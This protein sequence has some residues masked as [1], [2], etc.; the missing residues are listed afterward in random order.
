MAQSSDNAVYSSQVIDFVRVA[1]HFIDALIQPAP[2]K[3]SEFIR[4]L[5]HLLP[6]L[7]L[8]AIELPDVEAR[9]D[10]ANEK[11]VTE[12]EYE[13]LNH[14][15][16][17]RFGYLNDYLEILEPDFSEAD[18]PVPAS[19]AEDMADIYQDLKDFLMLY[20]MGNEDIMN[21]AVWECRLNFERYWGQKVL[22]SLRHIHKVLNGPEPIQEETL[23]P[24]DSERSDPPDTDQ[25][26]IARRQKDFQDP[27]NPE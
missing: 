20:Q 16:T 6:G 9:L 22:N 1:G 11:F 4:K 3:R 15:L 13:A 21:D 24:M 2:L 12:D 14:R 7:Y 27:D 17:A 18:G 8:K 19:L 26:F 25:W 23:P 10:G 5:Q